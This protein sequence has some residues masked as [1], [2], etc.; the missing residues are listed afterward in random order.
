MF[1]S[2]KWANEEVPPQGCSGW[3]WASPFHVYARSM[4]ALGTTRGILK[5]SLCILLKELGAFGEDE[6]V[7]KG[8]Q[9]WV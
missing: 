2:E 9:E 6:D 1:S 4:A 8:S 3:C 7:R 5:G